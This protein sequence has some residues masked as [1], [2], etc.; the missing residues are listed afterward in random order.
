VRGNG[1][2]CNISA[3]GNPV[4]A[5]SR[6]N[7]Y[8]SWG[9]FD[10]VGNVDEWVADWVDNSFEGFCTNWTTS[11]G[12]AGGDES[13]F[14]GSGGSGRQALPGALIRG[15]SWENGTFDGVFSVS[16]AFDPASTGFSFGFR[17]AR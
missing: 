17:C 8:S 5:G 10:M 3:A 13:C 9:V 15:G 11:A 7:C 16:A 2:D 1:T 12:I 6:Q 4:N 14:G